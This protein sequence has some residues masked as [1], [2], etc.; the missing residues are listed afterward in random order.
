MYFKN[1]IKCIIIEEFNR[2]VSFDR[3]QTPFII[4]DYD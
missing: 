4:I 1:F 2:F 3:L